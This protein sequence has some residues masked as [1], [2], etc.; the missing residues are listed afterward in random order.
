M[1]VTRLEGGLGHQLFQYAAGRRLALA[2]GVPL[3]VDCSAVDSGA[4]P[5]GLDPF[6][7][8][9]QQAPPGARDGFEAT[10]LTGRLMRRMRGQRLVQERS[11]RFDPAVLDLPGRAY[12]HGHWQSER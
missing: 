9:A 3:L 5:Y 4:R 6:H 8:D 12:L 2:R 10:T 11:P 1:I 7:I